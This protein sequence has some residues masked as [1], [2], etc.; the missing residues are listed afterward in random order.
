VMARMTPSHELP[1]LRNMWRILIHLRR[2]G[3]TSCRV[4]YSCHSL[5]WAPSGMH[6]TLCRATATSP[7]GFTARKGVPA[8]QHHYRAVVAIEKI[9]K[10]RGQLRD[11]DGV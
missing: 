6:A 9:G 7:S 10:D 11:R 3:T 5:T 4:G 2:S 8:H 1:T